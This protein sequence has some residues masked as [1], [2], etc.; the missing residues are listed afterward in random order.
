MLMDAKNKVFIVIG[1]VAFIATAGMGGLGLFVGSNLGKAT[2]GRSSSSTTANA[3]TAPGASSASTSRSGMPMKGMGYKDGQYT[4]SSDYYVP[5]GQ[6]TVSATVTIK[7]GAIASVTA[8]D[9]YSDGNSAYFV[10]NFESS[11]SSAASGQSLNGLYLSR[12]GGASLTTIAFD[13]VLDTIRSQA[14]A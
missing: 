13:N 1:S 14:S 12:V 8:N 10:S 6:N 3:A 7:N 5:G 11:I 9:N 2:L 4:A